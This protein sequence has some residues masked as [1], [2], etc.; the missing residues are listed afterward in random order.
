MKEDETIIN[1]LTKT[2]NSPE[3]KPKK[4]YLQK[5]LSKLELKKTAQIFK[6]L[7]YNGNGYLSLTELYDGFEKLNMFDVRHAISRAFY[8]T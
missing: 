6:K 3:A 7:D 1:T 8:Q 4:D 2:N 5:I